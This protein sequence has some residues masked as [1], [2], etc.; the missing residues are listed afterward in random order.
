MFLFYQSSLPDHSHLHF[1]PSLI[2][3][4]PTFTHPPKTGQ[5][6]A[7]LVASLPP[8]HQNHTQL[9]LVRAIH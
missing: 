8:D 4:R 9:P 5:L 1:A 2:H 3:S 7:F 6:Q